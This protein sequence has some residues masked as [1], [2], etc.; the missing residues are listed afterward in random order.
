M[1]QLSIIFGTI[2]F[3]YEFCKSGSKKERG[4]GDVGGNSKSGKIPLIPDTCHVWIRP[5][6]SDYCFSHAM[7]FIKQEISS[8]LQ[9]CF[10]N[11]GY[12]LT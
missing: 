10:K 5:H 8:A 9:T 7:S 6:S 1:I 3:Y 12:I 4:S 11:L 2:A